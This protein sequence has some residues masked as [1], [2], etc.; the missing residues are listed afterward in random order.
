MLLKCR[1]FIYVLLL[2]HIS[3]GCLTVSDSGSFESSQSSVNRDDSGSHN[4]RHRRQY[5]SSSDQRQLSPQC[6][7]AAGDYYTSAQLPDD[8]AATEDGLSAEYGNGPYSQTILR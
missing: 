3:A 6:N 5:P 2:R 1:I 7:G 8:D 4:H